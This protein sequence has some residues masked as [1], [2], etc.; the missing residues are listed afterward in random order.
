M[1]T[2]IAI[3]LEDDLKESLSRFIETL[4]GSG[5]SVRWVG[6]GSMHLTLKFLGEVTPELVTKIATALENTARK[7]RSFTLKLKGTGSFPPGKRNP[8][9]LWIGIQEEPLLLSLQ[10]EV[11]RALEKLGFPREKR[12]FHAHLTLG[13][14]KSPGGLHELL[15]E[16]SNARLKEFGHMMVTKVTFFQSTLK[17]TGA[18]YTVIS[19]SQLG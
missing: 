2:F 17:P 5:Q 8:R 11:E 13:R 15:S 9:V 6:R 3:D 1:R 16:F 18:E 10:D 4:P 14:V 7:C 19:E 12:P